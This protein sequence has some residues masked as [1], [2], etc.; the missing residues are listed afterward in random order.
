LLLTFLL[1]I[2]ANAKEPPAQVIVWPDSGP[3]V[4][5]FSFSRFKEVGGSGSQHNY[6]SDTTAENL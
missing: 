1:V 3:P 6:I 5:R 4:L 2:A